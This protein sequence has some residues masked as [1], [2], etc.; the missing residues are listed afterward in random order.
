ML[1]ERRLAQVEPLVQF[2]HRLRPVEQVAQDVQALLVAERLE[3]LGGLRR[4]RVHEFGGERGRI[5]RVG[6]TLRRARLFRDF[7]RLMLCGAAYQAGISV[8]IA[9]AAVYAEEA[10]GFAQQ[11]TMMLVFLVNVAAAVGAFAFGYVQDRIG[12][13]SALALTLVGWIVMVLIAGLAH[14]GVGEFLAA[15]LLSAAAM[16]ATVAMVMRLSGY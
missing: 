12:H 13:K 2:A 8:V 15:N 11:Q 3:E 7:W 16:L 10:M 14:L 9:L 5:R 1:R 6:A 4:M